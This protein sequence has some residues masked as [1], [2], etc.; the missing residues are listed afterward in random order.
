[1]SFSVSIVT[2]LTN[3]DVTNRN[4]KFIKRN[5]LYE[6]KQNEREKVQWRLQIKNKKF[7]LLFF[8]VLKNNC[9]S[10][11]FSIEKVCGSNCDNMLHLTFNDTPINDSDF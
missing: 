9:F 7:K 2:F 11:K 8:S 4:I 1:M 5:P 10:F 3:Y 6:N